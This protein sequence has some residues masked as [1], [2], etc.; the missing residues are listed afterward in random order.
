M[1]AIQNRHDFVLFF[2]VENGNPNGDPDAGNMPRV[3]PETGYGIVTDVCL[4]RKVRNFVDLNPPKVQESDGAA[5]HI[6]VKEKA[7]LNQQHDLAYKALSLDPAK[8]KIKAGDV[9]LARTWMCKNFYDV[10]T[11][12][13]VMSTGTNCGQVRGPVQIAFAKSCHPVVPRE[14]SITR[15]AVTTEKEADA[16]KGDNRTMGNKFIIPYALYRVHGFVSAPLAQRTGFSQKD[17]NLFWDALCNLFEHDR[18][19]SRGEMAARKLF[20]FTHAEALGNAPAHT[21]F[22]RISVQRAGDASQPPREFTDYTITV[23]RQNMPAGVSLEE[24]L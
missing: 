6:Y 2:D 1:N 9:D 20:V 4:K 24:K 7:I 11:F 21:L 23:D 15:M 22:E 5:Y 8:D 13:A 19:A 17:L 3:D 10:R 12:G 16:Q 14:V 18:S